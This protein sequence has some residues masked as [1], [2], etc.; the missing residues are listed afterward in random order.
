MK[1]KS[2]LF[3]LP[4]LLFFSSCLEKYSDFDIKSDTQVIAPIAYGSFNLGDILSNFTED[5]MFQEGQEDELMFI[6]REDEVLEIAVSNFFRF[7]SDVEVVESSEVLGYIRLRDSTYHKI[8]NLKELNER[9]SISEEISG[10]SDGERRIF[11]EASIGSEYSS[12]LTWEIEDFNFIREADFH[13]GMIDFTLRN[14]FPANCEG[15]F[16]VFDSE[17]NLIQKIQFGKRAGIGLYP[18]ESETTTFSMEGKTIKAPL[19]YK[20]TALHFFESDDEVI[21]EMNNGFDISVKLSNVLLNNG[22]FNSFEYTYNSGVKQIE[23]Y[24]ADDIEIHKA[25][26]LSGEMVF[27]INKGFEPSGD[28]SV[29]LQNLYKDGKPFSFNIKLDN[30]GLISTKFDLAGCELIL[31]EKN[32][33]PNFFEYYFE[34]SNSDN[35]F[36]KLSADEYYQYGITLQGLTY[37]YVEGYFGNR[38]INFSH[39]GFKFNQEIWDKVKGEIF[40]EDPLLNVFISYPSGIPI[41][42]DINMTAYNTNGQSVNLSYLDHRIE[43]PETIAESPKNSVLQFNHTN[44]NILDFIKLPPNDSIIFSVGLEMN[45]DGK[46]ET[47]HLNFISTNDILKIGMEFKVPIV[48]KGSFFNYYDTLFLA[49][50]SIL[51][52]VK[53]AE[54]IFRTKNTMPMQINL[55]LTPFDTLTNTVIGDEIF[56]RILDAAQTDEFGNV[57]AE[58]VAENKLIIEGEDLNNLRNSNALLMKA[59]LMSP[60]DGEKPAKLKFKDGFD[61]KIILNVTA[62]L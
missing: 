57:I 26:I 14:N 62:D 6:F 23:I 36:I 40:G 53:R 25:T 33:K 61:L 17:M 30:D 49:T 5:S 46:P 13:T 42:S 4:F 55:T 1:L 29:H 45:P 37:S 56:A 31:S 43:Y 35:E 39:Q 41:E 16:Q 24:F 10:F 60:S 58:T 51:K 28:I 54:M 18:S 52:N 19:Y 34:Y 20:I 27:N 59:S 21:I 15:E 8:I 12:L 2:T 22:I 48:V 50:G 44:S 11:P 38:V 32:S 47:E 9:V 7:P 3:V